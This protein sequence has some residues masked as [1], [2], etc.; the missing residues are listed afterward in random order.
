MQFNLK[1]ATH[2]VYKPGQVWKYFTREGEEDSE[3]T[4]LKIDSAEN[5]GLIIH[6][7]INGLKLKNSRAEN[8]FTSFVQHMPFNEEALTS[9]LTDKVAESSAMPDYEEGYNTWRNAF[10][11][12]HAGVFTLSVKDAIS[13]MEEALS[14]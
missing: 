8:G 10:E 13:A 12:G 5:I 2:D 11:K 9:S 6:V 4:I 3:L 7:S 1:E 14:N